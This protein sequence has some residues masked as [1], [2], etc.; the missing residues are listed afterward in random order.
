MSFRGRITI[1]VFAFVALPLSAASQTC[2]PTSSDPIDV[3]E[4]LA[5]EKDSSTVGMRNA[6]NAAREKWDAEMNASYKRLMAKLSPS[7]AAALR[8]SQ[9]AWIAFRD[10]EFA[11]ISAITASQEGTINQLIATGDGEEL[12]KTRALQLRGYE[13]SLDSP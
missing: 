12:V 8:K 2:V 1:S 11:S 10:A 6:S 5:I 9:R 3:A 4:Q 7:Q 13:A